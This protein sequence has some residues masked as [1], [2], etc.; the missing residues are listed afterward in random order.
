MV[1]LAQLARLAC[2]CVLLVVAWMLFEEVSSFAVL[3]LHP[4]PFRGAC[5][6]G[7]NRT[8]IIGD[9]HGCLE[10][11]T[12]LLSLVQPRRHCGKAG[13]IQ[14]FAYGNRHLLIARSPVL[15][16]GDRLIYVGDVVGKGPQPLE[17]LRSAMRSLEIVGGELLIGNHEAAALRWLFERKAKLAPHERHRVSPAARTVA[18]ALRPDE[19]H[20]LRS[21]PNFVSLEDLGVVVVH[22]GLAPNVPL[23]NQRNEH[24]ITMRSID[25]DGSP[26]SRMGSASWAEQR[27]GPPHVVFGH[28]ARRGLQ[29]HSWATGIDTGCVY[30]ASQERFHARIT[31]Q[32]Q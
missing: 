3:F 10:E 23:W 5:I 30:G 17:A 22:A 2:L 27:R 8:I 16:T 24:L 20:W 14:T 9:V 4:S 18:L 26:S 19:V 29:R 12:L 31:H 1:V 28:D 15:P 11:L 13:S 21:R 7:S 32:M 25:N 6:K